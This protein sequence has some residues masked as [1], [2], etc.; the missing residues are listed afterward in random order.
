MYDRT[1]WLDHV[2]SKSGAYTITELGDGTVNIT[3]AGTVMTQGTPQD[4]A[5]FNKQEEG[6]WDLYAAFGMLLNE[7]RQHRW[8]MSEELS[9]IDNKWQIVTGTVTL[10]NTGTYPY[11]NSQKSVSLG[12]NMGSTNYLVMVEPSTDT[13]NIGDIIVS[14][15]LVNGFKVAYNGSARS[16]TIKYTA[17]GGVLK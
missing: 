7:V 4:Q 6:I 3:R 11:N 1:F 2:T 15:K 12:C 13:G 16:A 9:P 5:H 10:N 8:K 17:I 14:D